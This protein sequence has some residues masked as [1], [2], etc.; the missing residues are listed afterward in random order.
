MDIFKGIV[1]VIGAV[2]GPSFMIWAWFPSK[3]KRA[4]LAAAATT[5]IF[6]T[7]V[8]VWAFLHMN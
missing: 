8:L 4:R 7:A 1:G 6:M 2:V 5:A 3:F